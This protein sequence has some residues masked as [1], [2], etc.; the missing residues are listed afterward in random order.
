MT[1]PVTA[2]PENPGKPLLAQYSLNS[3]E[4]AFKK[5]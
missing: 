1:V 3:L 2:I 5:K 4:E